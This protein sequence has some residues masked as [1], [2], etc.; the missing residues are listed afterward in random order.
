[1]KR[2]KKL[3][4]FIL[5]FVM[6]ITMPGV[7]RVKATTVTTPVSAYRCGYTLYVWKKDNS[8]VLGYMHTSNST[9]ADKRTVTFTT[10]FTA[11]VFCQE[12]TVYV[13]YQDSDYATNTK[14]KMSR[15]KKVGISKSKKYAG[16]KLAQLAQTY[17]K[18]KVTYD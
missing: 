11:E 8:A 12:A 10:T 15:G 6:V 17:G 1:M 4:A 7:V 18:C 13:S 2:K 16:E 9:A 14:S 5:T 3:A